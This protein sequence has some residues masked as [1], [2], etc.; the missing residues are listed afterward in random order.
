MVFSLWRTIELFYFG[1]MPTSRKVIWFSSEVSSGRTLMWQLMKN[2][3]VLVPL[4]CV[5]FYYITATGVGSNA[6]SNTVHFVLCLLHFEQFSLWRTINFL[7]IAVVLE[8]NSY[9]VNS[10]EFCVQNAKR[11]IFSVEGSA[12]ISIQK[13]QSSDMQNYEAEEGRVWPRY[14]VKVYVT[15]KNSK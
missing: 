8:S 3:L 15:Y 13:Q 5:E 14:I 11:S 6:L 12:L 1:V 4:Q 10:A 2:G 9:A 7:K